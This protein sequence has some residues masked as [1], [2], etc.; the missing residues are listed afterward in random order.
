MFWMITVLPETD[1]VVV[2][3]GV[4]LTGVALTVPAGVVG[5]AVAAGCPCCAVW[6]HPAMSRKTTTAMQ[7]KRID[8]IGKRSYV[9]L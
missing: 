9:S 2:T 5:V 1:V 4:A 3:T 6:V 8:F 7:R